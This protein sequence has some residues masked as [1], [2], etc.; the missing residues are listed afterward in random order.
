MTAQELT[1][2]GLAISAGVAIAHHHPIA[3]TLIAIIAGITAC[4]KW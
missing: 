4:N 2:L 3:A 1:G